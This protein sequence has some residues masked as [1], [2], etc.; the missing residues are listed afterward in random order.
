[1]FIGIFLICL[2]VSVV[3]LTVF[4]TSK[5]TSTSVVTSRQPYV[6]P[7][8][9]KTVVDI[10][11]KEDTTEGLEN[12]DLTY[13]HLALSIVNYDFPSVASRQKYRAVV[14]VISGSGDAQYQQLYKNFKSIW[15]A[16]STKNPNYYVIFLECDP[17]ASELI[18][19][20]SEDQTLYLK[21][22]DSIRPGIILKT[23]AG[24]SSALHNIDFQYLIRTNLSTFLNWHQFD[25][26]L[27]ELPDYNVYA[28]FKNREFCS[29]AVTFSRDVV[30]K[31]V[32]HVRRN[33]REHY[34]EEWDDVFMGQIAMRNGV[35]KIGINGGWFVDH[36][37]VDDK[38]K[39]KLLDATENQKWPWFRV[40]N[41]DSHRLK[42][43]TF[44]HEY[45]FQA[46]YDD[47]T[48]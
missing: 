31:L 28:G 20:S 8:L 18:S 32:D 25:S 3:L 1:M 11:E 17:F 46:L 37:D 27:D 33:A 19:W 44:I 34:W 10:A 36:A 39:E 38:L 7:S 14:L 16:Y 48:H 45:L 2:G 15:K 43:D 40:R 22:Q 35:Q 26:I 12:R 41:P 9:E 47:R 6:E 30:Q 24:M 21:T 42:V 23:L 13:A 5:D 4:L 29:V